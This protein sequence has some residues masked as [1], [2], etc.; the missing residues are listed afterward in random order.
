SW[1]EAQFG[2]SELSPMARKALL[3][4]RAPDGMADSGPT[5][6]ACFAV[7]LTAI[8]AAI[9]GGACDVDAVGRALKAGTNCGSCR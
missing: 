6:C 9:A 5:V 2:M 1:I 4:G 7:G 3:A 8:K